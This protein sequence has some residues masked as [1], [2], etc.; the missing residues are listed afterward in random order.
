M[1][2][3]KE[4]KR[5]IS[6][7]VSVPSHSSLLTLLGFS[8]NDDEVCLV[9]EYCEGGTLFDILYK[10]FYPFQ[11]SYSQKL[12]ILLDIAKGMQFLNELKT[13]IIHRDL[14]SLN[15]IIDRKI[16]KNSLNFVAKIIDF[17]LSRSFNNLNEF[18]T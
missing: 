15:I 8:I 13:P 18:V 11:L 1:K 17:G 3:L 5:E 16:E 12:K 2:F 4:F 14:K 9:T 10:K 6:L 7:L